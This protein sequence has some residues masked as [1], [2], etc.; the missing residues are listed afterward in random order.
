MAFAPWQCAHGDAQPVTLPVATTVALAPPDDSVD[1]NN[2]VIQGH[3]TVSSFGPAPLAEVLDDN[4][5]VVGLEPWQVTK[6][7]TWEPVG[8]QIVVAHNPPGLSLLGGV[9]RT[10][11]NNSISSFACDANGYW[12]EQSFIDTTNGGGGGGGGSPGP[13]GPAGPIGPAGPAGP[14]GPEGPSGPKGDKGDAGSQGPQGVPGT[15]GPQ[16][17]IG[18]VGPA[19]PVGPEGPPGTGGSGGGGPGLP[20]GRLTFISNTPVMTGNVTGGSIVY[21]TPYVGQW[22]PVWTGTT[23]QMLDPGGELSQSITDTTKSPAAVVANANYD[24]FVW[25]DAGVVRCTRGPAWASQTARAVGLQR[26]AGLLTNAADITN[27]PLAGVGTYVGTI[28]TDGSGTLTFLQGGAAAGGA[29]AFISLWNMYNRVFWSGM[30]ID[31]TASW[32]YAVNAWRPA[33]GSVA[34]RVTFVLGMP[35]DPIDARY[36]C[37]TQN[38]PIPGTALAYVGVGLDSVSAPSGLNT[39]FGGTAGDTMVL[40]APVLAANSMNPGAGRHFV[41]ALENS[42]LTQTVTFYG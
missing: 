28:T 3:G 36:V 6:Q 15:A 10:I 34:N 35:D 20:Q 5:D 33:N 13:P 38:A 11:T 42:P 2:V 40:F 9:T 39:G 7:V 4:G 18:P 32:T 1:T 29:Q 23:W 21:Y 27:G 41:Q 19:G 24:M 37:L 17:P 16:G 26:T 31:S 12:V 14:V 30:V 22:V 25:N 8:G